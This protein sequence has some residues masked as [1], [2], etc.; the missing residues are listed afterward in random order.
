MIR[1]IATDMDGTFLDSHKKFDKAFIDLFYAMQKQGIKFVVASGNQYYRLYQ[2]FLPLSQHMY[3]IA[4]N[5]SYIAQGASELSCHVMP[6]HDVMK[7]AVS[8]L[9]Y[10]RLVM[11]LCGRKG[12]YVLNEF[13]EYRDEVK[14]YYCAYSFVNSF[15]EIDDEIMKVAIY[16]KEHYVSDFYDDIV[17]WLP[18]HFK[19][20]TSGNE[21]L[22]IQN[23]GVNKGV[24]I[25]FLQSLYQIKPEECAA[26]GDQMNDYEMLKAVKYS[27][28]MSNAVTPIQDIAYQ[29]IGSHDE[30]AVI[31]QIKIILLENQ[32]ELDHQ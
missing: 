9:K 31:S 2:K 29:V 26:F 12:A 17:S 32:K 10:P 6:R 19:I 23:Q 1:L 21:W 5:G 8:L 20:V 18:P 3:F 14:K 13:L 27:Y 30:Q 15:D 16:D 11:I 4:E 7:V 25:Q 24:G 22:D 28:A